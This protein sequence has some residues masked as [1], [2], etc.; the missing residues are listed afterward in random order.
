MVEGKRKNPWLGLESYREGEVL[1]GRDDDI[2]DLSQCVLNNNDTLLYGK[3]GIGK[4]SILHACIIPAARRNGFLPVMVR[5]SH[6]EQLSYL[7]QI[8]EAI[9]NA[10]LPI[11]CDETGS[12]R[13]LSDAENARRRDELSSRIKEVVKCKDMEKEGL[14]EY[15]HRHAF[16]D[17]KGERIKLLIIF[18]QFEELFTLQTEEA[19]KKAFFSELADLL[20]DIM[21]SELQSSTD[22]SQEE[23]VQ[24]V[25][26][27]ENKI[28]DL[29]NDLSLSSDNALPEYVTDNE[30]HLVFTIRED[31]L[32]E[33]EYYSAAI[34]SLKQNR[35]GLRPLNEEQAAQIILRPEPGL[36][37]ES[38]AK[39][40]IEKV[41]GRTDFE[42]NGIPEIEV[43]SAVLSLYLNRLY[44]AKTGKHITSE[45]IE[46]KGGEIITDFYS[47]AISAISSSTVEYL[48][49][50]LLNGQGRRDNVTVFD[51]M[52]SGGITESE[53]D[54]LCNKKKILRQFNYADDLRIEFVHDILCPVVKA[55]KNERTLLRQQEEER[56]R[57]EEEKLEIQAEA[58]RKQREIEERAAREKAEL[59]AESIRTKLRNRK[60]LVGLSGIIISILLCIGMYYYCFIQPYS[61]EYG[62]FTTR[63]GW[64][65][66]LG[67]QL[68]SPMEKEQC[69]IYYKLTRAGRLPSLWGLPRPFTQVEI[70]NWKGEPAT[71]VL[72]GS[73]AVRL[74]DKELDDVKAGEFAT[75]LSQVSSW[76]YSADAD[77]EIAMC[78]AF[79]IHG[80]KLYSEKYSSIND[81]KESAKQVLWCIMND[82][83]GNA[84]QISD[85]GTDR[86][87]FTVSNGYIT[88]CSF[89]T[90]LETPQP[91][92][93][94]H[95]GYGYE[96]DTLSNNTVLRYTLDKY[97]DK[98]DSTLIHF[99]QFEHGRYS[100]TDICSIIYARQQLVWKFA[101]HTDSIHIRPNGFVDVISASVN[102]STRLWV[103]Y[104]SEGK[105]LKKKHY[106][107]FTLTD[108]T[109]CY[110]S[111]ARLDSI[112]RYDSDKDMQV[113]TEKYAYPSAN[114][115]EKTFWSK[116]RKVMSS[117]WYGPELITYH[118]MRTATSVSSSQKTVTTTF[119]D[120]EHALTKG[121]YSKMTVVTDTLSDN[122]LYQYYYNDKDEIY[123]SQMFTY[124]E[125]GIR[126][127]RS[128]AGIDGKP[129]RCPNWD[130]NGFTY[131]NMKFITNNYLDD[132]Y[133]NIKGIDELGEEIPIF[134]GS[135]KAL[136]YE[137]APVRMVQE[138]ASTYEVL[139]GVAINKVSLYPIENLKHV[140]FVHLLNKKG[141]FYHSEPQNK[142][143]PTVTRRIVDGDI[144]AQINGMD[145]LNNCYAQQHQ[146][147]RL[148]ADLMAKGGKMTILRLQ[149][150]KW[151]AIPMLIQAGKTGAE[152]HICPI[153]NKMYNLINKIL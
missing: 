111:S 73:P 129:V 81:A 138:L 4:S 92:T 59:E 112:R 28:D 45:L 79:N 32:S 53:L 126:E 37:S 118:K 137:E 123:K 8:Q 23:A 90:S 43:D 99:S 71:N 50:K 143:V 18:D 142:H 61:E 31:F 56:R 84:L 7:K 96:I 57:Q 119:Y 91:N 11:P 83:K 151:M 41:T 64:P 1:Y 27:D 93:S 107:R 130:W 78:T 117:G 101:N 140:A 75:L 67:E 21:P 25:V 114:V 34:P 104:L 85:R 146:I 38:V 51:A 42:L 24:A 19:K 124:N 36:I 152:Y 87:R 144:I 60:W 65:V 17:E 46:S 35:Y 110:Y 49:D 116:G 69:T 105:L 98:I 148:W 48:E 33:F 40:I 95:Y 10:M 134:N 20:N 147:D 150:G 29:F 77:G 63:Y 149:D 121:N 122:I 86:I 39:L 103:S 74:I 141:S 100:K 13:L 127:S 128:V 30:I 66:G 52:N 115:I 14:Y 12:Q 80:K 145:V 68:D 62:N 16:Y 72:I 136:R 82:S 106:S 97:G 125:Y 113:I 76:Q 55:H 139:R 108:S 94:G 3:S 15:F 5:L 22:E 44:D 26:F 132:G 58:E 153:S 102:D 88:G 120:C 131:Y 9:A 2:R 109:T 133:V 6:K 135:D 89:F 47:D 54:L 70:M